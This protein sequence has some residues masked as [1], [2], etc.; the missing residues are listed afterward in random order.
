GAVLTVRGFRAATPA[1]RSQIRWAA[2]GG[3]A[4]T[5]AG[6]VLLMGPELLTGPPLLPWSAV[7]LVALPLPLGVAAGILRYRLFD[8]EVV[9]NRTLVYG[10]LTGAGGLDYW[11]S[12][13]VRGGG[14]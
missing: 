7:G 1:V 6:V 11:G 2:I 5:L 9:V 10:G 8:I 13:S 12:A 4:A 3:G 14:G